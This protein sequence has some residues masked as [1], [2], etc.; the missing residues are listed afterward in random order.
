MTTE[1]ARSGNPC[2]SQAPRILDEKVPNYPPYEPEVSGEAWG[3]L[4]S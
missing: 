1:Q 4:I 3:G 2:R